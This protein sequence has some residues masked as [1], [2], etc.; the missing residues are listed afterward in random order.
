M[1][2]II[3]FVLMCVFIISL[4][5]CSNSVSTDINASAEVLYS[6]N[7]SI[8]LLI[9]NNIVYINA[10]N[11]DWISDFDFESDEIIGKITR[12][13]VKEKFK[14]FDATVLDVG[15]VL[16]SVSSSPSDSLILVYID[17]VAVPYYS[18]QEG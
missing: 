13:N 9:Y 7:N 2:K 17:D 18:Y 14:N 4:S 10:K 11:I 15:T 6:N 5:A 16:Y 12:T 8:D 3:A 1:K